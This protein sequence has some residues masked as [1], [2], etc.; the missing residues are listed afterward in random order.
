VRTCI[1]EVALPWEAGEDDYVNDIRE[2]PDSDDAP[3][4]DLAEAIR[5]DAEN[6]WAIA[7]RRRQ[8]PQTLYEKAKVHAQLDPI[9]ELVD[10]NLVGV[11]HSLAAEIPEVRVAMATAG[12][13]QLDK[14][15]MLSQHLDITHAIAGHLMRGEFDG[16]RHDGL[17][18]DSRHNGTNYV[19]FEDR[20][21]IVRSSEPVPLSPNDADVLG[22]AAELGWDP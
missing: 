19:L 18:C 3:D 2:L 10:L 11:R 4:D 1:Y 20:F 5:R 7:Q 17:C 8:L 9:A 12:L 22:V 15:V 6:D 16:R 13:R 21:R 14:S